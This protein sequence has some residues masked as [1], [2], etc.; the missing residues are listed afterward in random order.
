MLTDRSVAM[1]GIDQQGELWSCNL[2]FFKQFDQKHI[3]YGFCSSKAWSQRSSCWLILAESGYQP[4]VHNDLLAI[5][6]TDNQFVHVL[7]SIDL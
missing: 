2:H 7:M 6:S 3:E 1:Q 5:A 4:V